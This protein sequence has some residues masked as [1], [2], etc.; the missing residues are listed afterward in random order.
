MEAKE[1]AALRARIT[2]LEAELARVKTQLRKTYSDRAEI[3]S[4][5][6]RITAAFPQNTSSQP[7]P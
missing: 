5:L 2:V 6:R 1:E 7:P 3:H 4:R